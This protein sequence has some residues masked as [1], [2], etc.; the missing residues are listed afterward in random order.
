MSAQPL[1]SK[2]D[3]EEGRNEF[4]ANLTSTGLNK[5]D[6]IAKAKM[7]DHTQGLSHEEAARRLKQYGTSDGRRDDD[8]SSD[9][10]SSD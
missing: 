10:S 1:V 4:D 8:S 9:D 7:T 3:V 6:E 2:A 5:E